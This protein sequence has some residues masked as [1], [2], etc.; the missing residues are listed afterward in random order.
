[1]IQAFNEDMP[2]DLFIKAQIAADQLPVPNRD[3]L[4]PA[5]GFQALGDLGFQGMGN[6]DRVD[7]L[8]RVFWASR[9]LVLNATTTSTTLF[10]PKTTTRCWVSS[11]APNFVKFRSRAEV[12][13]AYDK[14]QKKIANM[15]AVIR[16]FEEKQNN[17]LTDILM[18]QTSR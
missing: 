8:T 5:L 7:V 10:Q 3:K 2:Y 18:K 15:E 4:L 12:V 1:M 11:R 13:E 16:D 17:M 14:H 9:W 6:D